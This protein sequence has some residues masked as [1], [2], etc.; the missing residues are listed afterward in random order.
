MQAA[1]IRSH[2]GPEVLQ[3]EDLPSPEPDAGE[4]LVQVLAV[5]V[6]HL[7]LWVRRGMPGVP[8][9]FPRILGCDGTGEVLALGEDV[10]DC[11]LEVG[12]KVVIQPG[13]SSGKSSWDEAG[14]DHLSDDYGIRGE[15]GDGLDCEQVALEPRFLTPL[16][17]GLDPVEAA[18]MPLTF[19]TAWGMLVTR[20]D[21]EEGEDVLILGGTSGVGVAGIQIAKARGARV[22]ATAG[23]EAKRALCAELGADVVIDHHEDGWGKAVKAATGGRGVDLV[24]EHVGPATWAESMRALARNGRLVTCGGTTGPKVS[25]NLPHLFIKNL[26]VLGSTMGPASAFP[27]IFELAAE[28]VFRPVVDRVLPL[29]E[30]QSAHAAL[31]AGGVLGK[32]VLVPGS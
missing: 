18:A 30:I 31:E 10:Q 15:H 24:M 28:G 13:Y 12:Q 22:I 21:V 14:L 2:G 1:L 11:G 16:P 23:T 17:D 29:S 5:S 9:P 4:V 7:D 27:E 8:I 32:I 26:S 19:L 25:L 20:A 3:L 6:N